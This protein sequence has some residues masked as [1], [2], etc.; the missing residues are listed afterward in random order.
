MAN[1][2]NPKSTFL[3]RS[4]QKIR[5][6]LGVDTNLILRLMWLNMTTHMNYFQTHDCT[7]SPST[8]LKA[9]TQKSWSRIE[10]NTTCT[11]KSSVPDARSRIFHF[12]RTDSLCWMLVYLKSHTLMTEQSSKDVRN[13]ETIHFYIQCWQPSCVRIISSSGAIK[14]T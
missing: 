3:G 4:W 8:F 1:L 2:A 11:E 12:N 10:R 7:D 9:I 13:H 5:S 6:R 14:R